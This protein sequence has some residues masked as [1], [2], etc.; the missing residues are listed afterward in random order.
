[1][2]GTAPD[3]AGKNI[4]N[5]LSALFS[6]VMMLEY[7]QEFTHANALKTTSLQYLQ[8]GQGFTPNLG[9]NRTTDGV[10]KEIMRYL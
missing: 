5:P 7:I 10:F 1:M 2:S 6:S 4:A 8:A 9:G 3:I